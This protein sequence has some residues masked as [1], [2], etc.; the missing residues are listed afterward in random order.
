MHNLLFAY[1]SIWAVILGRLGF[2][3]WQQWHSSRQVSAIS[4]DRPKPVELQPWR[5]VTT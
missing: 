5:T 4:E 3:E 1:L 2:D